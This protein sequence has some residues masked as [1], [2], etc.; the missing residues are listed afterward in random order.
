MGHANTIQPDENKPIIKTVKQKAGSKPRSRMQDY[1]DQ[2]GQDP[3]GSAGY[4]EEEFD[5]DG[6]NNNLRIR[7]QK[8]PKNRKSKLQQHSDLEGT[9]DQPQIIRIAS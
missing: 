9:G 2:H 8:N 7:A 3:N 4:E 5:S 6:V 1:V